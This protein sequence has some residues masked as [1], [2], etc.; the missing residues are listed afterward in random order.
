MNVNINLGTVGSDITTV[1][2]SGCTGINS[3]NECTGCTS[4]SASEL[5]SSFPKVVGGFTNSM[6]Y[7][8]IQSVG[9][10]CAGQTQCLY[11]QPP[12]Q[13]NNVTPTPTIT[14]T[15]TPTLTPDGGGSSGGGTSYEYSITLSPT[16]A[17][18][19]G[20]AYG[21][22]ITSTNPTYPQQFYVTILS[23][24]GTVDSADFQSNFP[25]SPVILYS[26]QEFAFSLAEDHKTEGTE[27][28]K[29]Q[30]RS[31]SSSGTILATSNEVTITDGS[32]DIVYY[33][34]RPCD[35]VGQ[36][37]YLNGVYDVYSDG[38]GTFNSGERVEGSTNYF[39]VV[40]GSTTID[41]G[42]TKYTVTSTGLTGCPDTGG[43]GG[44]TYT[45][46][47]Y[48]TGAWTTSS[49][50]TLSQIKSDVC[51]IMPYQ[52]PGGY[53]Q[54]NQ[55]GTSFY[56][57]AQSITPGT[58]YTLYDA[59]TGGNVVNGG[60]KWYAILWNGGGSVYTYV[61]Y[62]TTEGIIQDW[63]QCTGT[64]ITPTPTITPTLTLTPLTS[65]YQVNIL[66]GSPGDCSNQSSACYA[67]NTMGTSPDTTIYTESGVL[68]D[69]EIAYVGPLGPVDGIFDG[70]MSY[71]T[72]GSSYGRIGNN[73]IIAIFDSCTAS[74]PCN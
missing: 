57:D 68:G 12:Q 25:S 19:G 43:G 29:L 20:G 17:D 35:M 63:T 59:S 55:N 72:D 61:A 46:T 1:A 45:R 52:L 24:V 51:G 50:P 48:L 70:N 74:G 47:A 7:V 9:G 49:G 23:T 42:G 27:K 67:F 38:V 6:T 2:I 16:T 32:L 8:H 28:F 39:Y 44:G 53:T 71:Y 58:Q 60:N 73:G 14:P 26:G 11:I 18:D 5:V 66:K 10:S 69:G 30:L 64:Q 34:L 65:Y 37:G 62:I 22:I 54:L 41:P 40:V 4:I 33:Q 31:G 13:N 21:A 15:I 56:V 36:P 3:S